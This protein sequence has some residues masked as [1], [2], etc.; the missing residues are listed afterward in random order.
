MKRKSFIVILLMLGSI[1][2]A[3]DWKLEE[4]CHEGQF[5]YVIKDTPEM[6]RQFINEGVFVKQLDDIFIYL[7]P[8][9]C[10]KELLDFLNKGNFKIEKYRNGEFIF[11]SEKF[12]IKY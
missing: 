9:S 11:L 5:Y 3:N 12:L 4:V 2:F 6:Y 10:E 7:F 8:S 1:L